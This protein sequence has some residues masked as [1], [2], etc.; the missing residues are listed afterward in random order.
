MANHVGQRA[1][2]ASEGAFYIPS[3]D[4]LRAFAV[5]LVFLS[6]AWTERW[7]PGNFGVTVFFFLSGYLITT[8]LR[9]EHSKT[10]RIS[11]K[12]F[13]LRRTLR[14]MPPFYLVLTIASVLT[15]VGALEGSVQLVPALF[16]V[17]DLSNYYLIY[18]GWWTGRAPGTWVY[19]SLA[20]EEH[21]Y[22]VFPVAYLLL[23]RLVPSVRRQ[24]LILLGV[25]AL[26]LAWRCI[27][28][29]GL[30]AIRDRT[31]VATDTR[32]DSILFGCIL[33]IYANPAL[34]LPRVSERHMKL[35]WLPL[36]IL[37]LLVSF[38]LRLPWFEETF[39]YTLQ[40]L[41]LFPIFAVA[42]RYP[43]WSFM[44]MLNVRWV[45]FLGVLSYSFYLL[46]PTVIFGIQQWVPWSPLLRAPLSLAISLTLSLMIYHAVEKP[47]ARLRRRLSRIRAGAPLPRTQA[48]V[49]PEDEVSKDRANAL[50]LPGISLQA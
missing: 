40:G 35:L 2:Q 38:A 28:V 18:N 36:G 10:G 31:Y 16:Q 9:I 46:H 8:L 32:I 49:G 43:E 30:H 33:A 39:R 50:P 14:I 7:L 15:V 6:H 1:S 13:Y 48:Q 23:R 44:Q 21:F 17:L 4:G 19:W 34:D 11:F 47:C 5:M 29:F 22:L 27:L 20:V 25:C 26:V 37:G 3:L 42:I 12:A 45:K 24:V 41:S